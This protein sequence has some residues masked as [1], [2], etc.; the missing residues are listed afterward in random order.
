MRFKDLLSRMSN[1]REHQRLRTRLRA[2]QYAAST[3]TLVGGILLE[4][5]LAFDL[6]ITRVGGPWLAPEMLQRVH[7]WIREIAA[8]E[9]PNAVFMDTTTLYTAGILSHD[10]DGTY[11]SPATLFDLAT[12][13]RS[14]ILYDHIFHLETNTFTSTG[15]NEELGNDQ[16]LVEIPVEMFDGPYDN[17]TLH[18]AGAFL[19]NVFAQTMSN[20]GAMMRKASIS[21]TVEFQYMTRIS[22]AWSHLLGFPIPLEYLVDDDD[23]H[24]WRSDGRALLEDLLAP[25][26]DNHGN[27]ADIEHEAKKMRLDNST[28]K[29][30]VS[31]TNHRAMFNAHIARALQLPYAPS[32]TRIPFR[33]YL[34]E[35][36]GV[37]HEGLR[38]IRQLD[39]HLSLNRGAYDLPKEP[40]LRLPV[41][42]SI[43]LKRCSSLNQFYEVLAELRVQAADFRRLRR[44]YEQALEKPNSTELE[45]LRKAIQQDAKKL[46][47]VLVAPGASAIAATIATAAGAP[48]LEMVWMTVGLLTLCSQL[49]EVKREWLIRRLLRPQEWFLS[50]IAEEGRAIG[51]SLADVERLWKR[52]IDD[53]YYH[54]RLSDLSHL[55]YG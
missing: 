31:E 45:S 22:K 52:D 50:N 13:A 6:R 53:K 40:N 49:D 18:G 1:R 48:D 7:T 21:D 11:L 4:S 35:V 46:Y 30:F 24:N 42:L 32:V 9:E 47:D 36:S 28:L 14:V 34:Y 2:E 8:R 51:D 10:P 27:V 43:V 17:S 15:I 20:L 41:F 38:S 3:D 33:H 29:R 12:F 25:F 23:R 39:Q 19:G 5:V 16:V 54:S 55:G 44:E 37:I 26:R